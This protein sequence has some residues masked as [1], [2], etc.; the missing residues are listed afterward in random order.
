MSLKQQ[1]LR[2]PFISA[3]QAAIRRRQQ[4]RS[5]AQLQTDYEQRAAAGGVRVLNENELRDA[6]RNRLAGRPHPQWPKRKGDLHIFL[7]YYVSTSEF[8][9]PQALA[10]FGKVTAFQWRGLGFDDRKADWLE[11]RPEMNRAMLEA[12][13]AANKERPVDAVVGYISGANT[14]PETLVEMAKTGAAIF[15]HSYDDT[16]SF[17]GRMIGGHYASTAALAPV[18]DLNLTSTP[19]SLI[20]YAM[21]DGLAMFHPE[22]AH[23]DFHKPYDVPFDYDVGFVGIRYGWRGPFIEKLQRL[24]G[25]QVKLGLFGRGWPG[26]QISDEDLAKLYSRSRINLGFSGVGF[27]RKLMCLKGRDFEVPM[28]GGLY[29]TQDNPDLKLVFDIGKEILTY[30]DEED[31]ARIIREILADPER[32]EVIRHAGRQR[33]LRDHTYEARWTKP[34]E[35]A[36][37]LAE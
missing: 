18:V 25:P 12:F 5:W 9:L 14:N 3:A 32:A 10:P 28:S 29:L 1:L 16:L 6:V 11:R 37:L 24:L 35:L 27:S 30:K 22:A 17:P 19:S 20:R 31:C 8:I 34:L 33:A 15:N 2:I 36:G 21:H 26:G 4:E 23:A 13:H 7:A